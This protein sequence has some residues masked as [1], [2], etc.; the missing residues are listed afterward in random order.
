MSEYEQLYR[1]AERL[2][3]RVEIGRASLHDVQRFLNRLTPAMRAQVVDLF[4]VNIIAPQP[5]CTGDPMP[6]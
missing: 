3:S 2:A 4:D 1:Q 6:E 5:Y